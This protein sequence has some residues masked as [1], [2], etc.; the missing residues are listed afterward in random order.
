MA[1]D[2]CKVSTLKNC[3]FDTAFLSCRDKNSS[4]IVGSN[5]DSQQRLFIDSM[6]GCAIRLGNDNLIAYDVEIRN[7]DGHS[8]LDLSGNRLNPDSVRC[9]NS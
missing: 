8:I 1:G 2:S 4:I 5:L 7:N 3:K 9:R 6:E